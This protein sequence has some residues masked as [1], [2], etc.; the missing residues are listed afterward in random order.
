MRR[1]L[2][3][4]RKKPDLASVTASLMRNN[5]SEKIDSAV[6]DAVSSE[7][8]LVSY[9]HGKA[10]GWSVETGSLCSGPTLTVVHSH[11]VG[12]AQAA[13]VTMSGDAHFFAFLRC[14]PSIITIAGFVSTGLQRE[15]TA[16][17]IPF[18]GIVRTGSS[19]LLS[20]RSLVGWCV[21]CLAW[22]FLR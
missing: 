1:G 7:A 21:I 18:R 12:C 13:N 22:A 11:D 15:A 5:C 10:D 17:P 16:G 4:K 19:V 3:K 9:R 8:S 6:I 2:R 14:S 20:T